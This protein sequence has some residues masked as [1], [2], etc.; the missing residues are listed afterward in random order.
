VLSRDGGG[1]TRGIWIRVYSP[2]FHNKA[3]PAVSLSL[4]GPEPRQDL[5]VTSLVITS[6]VMSLAPFALGRGGRG[7]HQRRGVP[8]LPRETGP[9]H[10]LIRK[11]VVNLVDFWIL[12]LKFFLAEARHKKT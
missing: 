10:H 11:S 1:N 7:A 8:R 3:Q 12:T 9:V 5:V 2:Q 6:L 4:A